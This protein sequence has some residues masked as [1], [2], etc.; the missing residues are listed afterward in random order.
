MNN[1]EFIINKIKI[2][3]FF[4]VYLKNLLSYLKF[5]IR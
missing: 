2:F 3:Y 5:I 1:I 4:Q